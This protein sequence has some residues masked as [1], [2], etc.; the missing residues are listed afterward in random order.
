MRN[1]NYSTLAFGSLLFIATIGNAQVLSND[2]LNFNTLQITEKRFSEQPLMNEGRTVQIITAADIQ[3]LP[4]KT[5]AEVLTYV[6]GID[7]DERGVLGAQ[8]DLSLQG[9]GFEQTLILVNGIPMR[10][11]QTGHHLMNLPVDINQIDRIEITYGAAGRLYG[12]NALSGAINIVTKK[13]NTYSSSFETFTGIAD[14]KDN[15]G[16]GNALV[17]V[18]A[19]A[20]WGMKKAQH[21]IGLGF[22]Q[23]DGY[24]YNSANTQYKVN[25]QG[26]VHINN[27]NYLDLIGGTFFNEFG[28]NGFYA[29]PY[30]KD[31]IETV[32]T[33]Y[34]ALQSSIKK[35]KWTLRPLAYY[36]YN[37]DHY[38]FIANKPEVYQ[39]WHFGTTAGAELHASQK[40]KWGN[41]GIGLESRGEVLASNN[42]G[43][44]ARYYFNAYAEQR[45][46]IGEKTTVVAGVNGQF[47]ASSNT[48]SF[49]PG[50]EVNQT[51]S[52]HVRVY[53]NLGSGNRMASFTEMYYVGPG[54]I[55]NDSLSSE[56][57]RYAEIGI[58]KSGNIQF[59]GSAFYRQVLNAITYTREEGTTVWAPSN[60]TQVTYMGAQFNAA[61]KMTEKANF[62]LNYMY[63]DAKFNLDDGIETKYAFEHARHRLVGQLSYQWTKSFSTLLAGRYVHRF[64]GTNYTLIDLRLNWKLRDNVHMTADIT[65]VLNRKYIDSGFVEMPGRWYRIGFKFN[66]NNK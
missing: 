56:M 64:I 15:N 14:P 33:S 13:P 55:G 30:D 57:A 12:S 36:R 62:S 22:L 54:N 58:R 24:R 38:V 7:L 28:A 6:A 35:D 26:R 3:T 17:G 37:T 19:N 59:N 8:A 44:R 60:F 51:V 21:A 43:K 41:L 42:L 20:T 49:F 34:F 23:N 27:G 4:V 63:L 5:V 18:Y 48:F 40:N 9:A 25:Y 10:D 53:A 32:N 52:D 66:L 46:S 2:T 47:N 31:A 65:N 16:N 50:I 1:F 45:I 29:A 61:T 11:A 39:N